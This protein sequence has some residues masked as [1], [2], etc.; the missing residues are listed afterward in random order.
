[1]Y[2]YQIKNISLLQYK[3][4][5]RNVLNTNKGLTKQYGDSLL[6]EEQLVYTY[7]KFNATML[8]P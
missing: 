6:Q 8:L 2:L 1:M 7:H 4:Q 3:L 5:T